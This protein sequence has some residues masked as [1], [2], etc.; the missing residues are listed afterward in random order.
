MSASNW[1]I[2]PRC[3]DRANAQA[4]RKA[5]A[6]AKK[7]GQ[8]PVEEFDQLRAALKPVKPEDYRT[9]RED[10]EFYGAEGGLVTATYGGQC[11]K[12]SLGVEFQEDRQFYVPGDTADEL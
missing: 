6:V 4:A 12:C 2:C 3:L 5:A 9:F 8:V 11:S 7:Y 10:Y 1:A